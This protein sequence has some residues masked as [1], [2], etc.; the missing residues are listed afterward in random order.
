MC[1]FKL[2]SSGRH[3]FRSPYVFNPLSGD[4]GACLY[5][6]LPK[7][8]LI[9]EVPPGLA[10]VVGEPMNIE[11]TLNHVFCYQTLP[12]LPQLRG[13]AKRFLSVC[14]VGWFK[15]HAPRYRGALQR[16]IKLN[17]NL[18]VAACP[19]KVWFI[20]DISVSCISTVGIGSLDDLLQRAKQHRLTVRK[21]PD[22]H[23][24]AECKRVLQTRDNQICRV[25]KPWP[26]CAKTSASLYEHEDIHGIS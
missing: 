24:I 18:I 9:D 5:V 19:V 4:T 13:L 20:I 26:H 14:S 25:T 3:A 12:L 10:A 21:T 8:S 17:L 15:V 22:L 7:S 16:G 2:L 1:Y 11:D 6:R 23:N